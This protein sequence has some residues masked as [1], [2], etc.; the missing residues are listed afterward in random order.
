MTEIKL[1]PGKY[2]RTR[3]GRKAYCLGFD[4]FAIGKDKM[5]VAVKNNGLLN[6]YEDGSYCCDDEDEIDIIDEWTEK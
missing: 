6:Y 5:A 1:Q 4:P 2:Y 3:D